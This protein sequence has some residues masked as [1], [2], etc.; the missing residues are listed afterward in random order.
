MMGDLRE[1]WKLLKHILLKT[2]IKNITSVGK[3][4]QILFGWTIVKEV[5]GLGVLI[6]VWLG[7]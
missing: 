1:I 6:L 3:N 7:L 2:V 4:S 5:M